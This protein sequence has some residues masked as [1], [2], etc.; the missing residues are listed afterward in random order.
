MSAVDRSGGSPA[1]SD[2]AARLR[3][4]GFVRFVATPDGDALAATGVLARARDGPF[5]ASVARGPVDPSDADLTVHVGRPG[6]DVALTDDPLCVT[7]AAVADELGGADRVLALAGVVAAGEEPGRYD[8]LDYAGL[9]RAPGVARPTDDLVDAL[10]HTTLAHASFSG[11][12]DA[13][14]EALDGRDHPRKVASA[15]A[16]S[17]VD[18]APER[19]ADAVQRALHPYDVPGPFRTLEG[20]ADV[21]DATART[22]P[23]VGVAVALGYADA[24]AEDEDA[25]TGAAQRRDAALDAWREHARSAHRTVRDAEYAR[26][27]GVV[28]ARVDGP[29]GTVARLVRD[30]RSPEPVAVAVD[31]REV[32]VASADQPVVDTVRDAADAVGGSATGRGR[33]ARATV[34]ESEQEAFVEALRRVVA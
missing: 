26:H 30:F 34:P 8:L 32:A 11:D 9:E 15:L 25:S 29:V 12:V 27:R 3:D 13:T 22:A 20:Y 16:L 24:A 23:G 28:V 7:A 21:L 18:D 14:R 10:A 19:A 17:C 5:Q 33:H 4:A 31:V 2:I 1:A 6:G